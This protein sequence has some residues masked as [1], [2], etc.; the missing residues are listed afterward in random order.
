VSWKLFWQIGILAAE[1]IILVGLV[2][3]SWIE[4]WKKK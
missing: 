2:V 3:E 4:S 1:V